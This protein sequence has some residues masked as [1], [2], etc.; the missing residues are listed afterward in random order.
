MKALKREGRFT[1]PIFKTTQNCRLSIVVLLLLL[2]IIGLRCHALRRRL[3]RVATALCRGLLRGQWWRRR[4]RLALHA[5]R[6]NEVVL[7]H[8]DCPTRGLCREALEV[9]RG[10]AV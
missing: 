9:Q 4:V 1:L 7:A 5:L 8:S 6:A 3:Q 2:A 10:G